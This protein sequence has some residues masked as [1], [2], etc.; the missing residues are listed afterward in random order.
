MLSKLTVLI[1]RKSLIFA[2]YAF[3]KILSEFSEPFENRRFSN[4]G[5]NVVS[6]APNAVKIYNFDIEGNL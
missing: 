2:C 3:S 4:T 1:Q 5:G 6:S